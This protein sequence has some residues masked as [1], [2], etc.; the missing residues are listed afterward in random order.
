MPQAL[1]E[2]AKVGIIGKRISIA[3]RLDER[4]EDLVDFAVPLEIDEVVVGANFTDA[5]F[6]LSAERIEIINTRSGQRAL[7]H[8]ESSGIVGAFEVLGQGF[9]LRRCPGGKGFGQ[10]GEDGRLDRFGDGQAIDDVVEAEQLPAQFHG[11]RVQ[12][13]SGSWRRRT[14]NAASHFVAE[15]GKAGVEEGQIGCHAVVFEEPGLELRAVDRLQGGES[16]EGQLLGDYLEIHFHQRDRLP[17]DFHCFCRRDHHQ[18]LHGRSALLLQQVTQ[19]RHLS[20]QGSVLGCSAQQRSQFADHGVV[21]I[22]RMRYDPVS[23]TVQN[24][25]FDFDYVEGTGITQ[26]ACGS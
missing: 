2:F 1:E 5:A 4:E 15:H 25:P 12:S 21:Q 10:V 17:V 11:S 7:P 8:V 23:Q 16:S 24:A 13:G 14:Q 20:R 18:T 22:T 19:H 3:G 6:V 26:A 9:Q